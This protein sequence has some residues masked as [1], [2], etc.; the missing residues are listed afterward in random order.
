[1]LLRKVGDITIS[2]NKCIMNT[3]CDGKRN[4][5]KGMGKREKTLKFSI[6]ANVI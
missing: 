4:M 6:L 3:Y 2:Q 1:M 5:R